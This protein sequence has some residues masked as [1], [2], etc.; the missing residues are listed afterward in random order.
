MSRITENNFISKQGDFDDILE[1]IGETAF[2]DPLEQK[3]GRSDWENI[4]AA[5]LKAI[6]EIEYNKPFSD[7]TIP[8][9]QK[10]LKSNKSFKKPPSRRTIYNHLY[11]LKP[12][13]IMTRKLGLIDKNLVF[14]TGRGRYSSKM[15]KIAESMAQEFLIREFYETVPRL[16]GKKFEEFL[17]SRLSI[18]NKHIAEYK[19]K[20]RMPIIGWFYGK[21]LIDLFDRKRNVKTIIRKWLYDEFNFIENST[22]IKLLS[23]KKLP[24]FDI[25]RLRESLAKILYSLLRSEE[26]RTLEKGESFDPKSCS[27]NII[28][29]FSPKNENYT[30]IGQRHEQ[31]HKE[32]KETVELAKQFFPIWLKNR[33]GVSINQDI[34]AFMFLHSPSSAYVLNKYGEKIDELARKVKEYSKRNK[35]GNREM[36]AFWQEFHRLKSSGLLPLA[37]DQKKGSN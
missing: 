27:L 23:S 5:I 29:S 13:Q 26:N 12:P 8:Q 28:V 20:S 31:Q 34:L 33:K 3:K 9:I 21:K 37:I 4:D 30:S 7:V 17:E 32:R 24:L 1:I 15:A 16:E 10:K 36:I 18:I 11:G 14:K 35:I 22:E 25:F 19:K 2:F 6:R